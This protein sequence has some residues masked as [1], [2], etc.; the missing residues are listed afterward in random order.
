MAI[1]L[2]RTYQPET[3]EKYIKNPEENA[4]QPPEN[5]GS[6]ENGGARSEAANQ[7][8][9]GGVMEAPTF[10][11]NGQGDFV[12][13]TGD[14]HE[15]NYPPEPVEPA[16]TY[17]AD[18][19]RGWD[20]VMYGSPAKDGREAVA[21]A[22]IPLAAGYADY[23]RWAKDNN[24]EQLDPYVTFARYRDYDLNKSITDN[25]KEEKRRK[26]QEKWERLGNLFSHVGNLVGTAMGAP[27]QKLE[28]GA[29]LTARQRKIRDDVMAQ[30]RRD[31][32]DWWQQYNNE[33]NYKM[34]EAADE[35]NRKV[36]QQNYEL[37]KAAD[38]RAQKEA[39][40]KAAARK[41]DEKRR[42]DKTAAEIE[43]LKAR[44]A[45]DNAAAKNGGTLNRRSS[46]G[47]GGR[48]GGSGKKSSSTGD[49]KITKKTDYRGR[50]TTTETYTQPKKTTQ[51]QKPESEKRIN[52]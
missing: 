3:G 32:A 18:W 47:S 5:G 7:P 43:V 27:S 49:V 31:Y 16:K 48:K 34:R 40:D 12:P 50:T 26:N 42:E 51:P 52:W 35:Y 37:R 25:E 30:R 28:S 36:A 17:L 21:P 9:A 46:G 20:S 8:P 44:A 45:R 41:A 15:D 10:V 11:E 1:K 22:N 2:N 4:P 14:N 13:Y 39:E 6:I 38:E 23:N 24:A 33:R 29:E 19:S